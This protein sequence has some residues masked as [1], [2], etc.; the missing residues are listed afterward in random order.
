[1][2]KWEGA[3]RR[4]LHQ[5]GS[6]I[7]G[8]RAMCEPTAHSSGS[9]WIIA[10]AP[11]AVAAGAA[12]VLFY[13]LANSELTLLQSI[14]APEHRARVFGLV[15]MFT[16]LALTTIPKVAAAARRSARIRLARCASQHSR[17]DAILAMVSVG[18]AYSVLEM[19]LNIAR[20][21]AALVVTLIAG[22]I[23]MA[24]LITARRMRVAELLIAIAVYGLFTAWLVAQ[25]RITWNMRTGFLRAYSQIRG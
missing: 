16:A 4:A 18:A 8:R 20:S 22:L 11:L 5:A 14:E 21:P 15:V 9:A 12:Y 3:V 1:M 13:G 6:A 19:T 2:T 17:V 24:P 10:S 25:P 23:A 7:L